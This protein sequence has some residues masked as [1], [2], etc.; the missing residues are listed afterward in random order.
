MDMGIII[1]VSTAAK[2]EEQHWTEEVSTA[3]PSYSQFPVL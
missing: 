3:L 1:V 2:V